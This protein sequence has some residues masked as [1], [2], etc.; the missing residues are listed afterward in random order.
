M[1]VLQVP[2][3]TALRL[4]VLLCGAALLAA[5]ASEGPPATA[6]RQRL[7][8]VVREQPALAGIDGPVGMTAPDT[9]AQVWT[10]APPVT[11][12]T[13]DSMATQA[14]KG[15]AAIDPSGR[16]RAGKLRPDRAPLPQNPAALP[17]SSAGASMARDR[18]DRPLVA[19]T[20]ASPNADVATLAATG[21]LPPDTMGDIGPT[22]YLVT[23]NGRIR[24]IGKTSGSADGVLDQDTDVFFPPAVRGAG[25]T[26]DPRVRYDRRSG[27]WIV[28]MITVAVPNRFVLAVSDGATITPGTTWSYYHWA[29]TRTQAGSGAIGCLADYP[30]LGVDEDALYVGVNQFC[31]TDFSGL[32]FDSVSVY[33]VNKADLVGGTL[34]LAQFDG[35]LASSSSAGIYSPQGVDNVDAN[36]ST[37]YV[38][39]V[40]NRLLGNLILHRIANPGAAPSISGPIDIA[41]PPTSVPVDVPHPGGTLP[42]DGL[43]DRLLQAVVRNGRLWTTHQVEVDAAGQADT[44]GGRNGVRWYELGT[45]GATPAVVQSG[46]V[47]DSAGASPVSYWMGA[48]MANG[49]GHVALGM[50]MAGAAT[51]VNTAFTGRLASDPSAYPSGVMDPPTAYSS[52][53]SFSYNQQVP[54]AT[55]QR[56]GDYSYTSVDPDD[57]MTFWTLQQ[58]VDA[59]NSYAVRLVRLLAPPPAAITSVSP[60]VID[61]GVATVIVTV[62]GSATGGRGFFDPG[63]GF[64]RRIAAAVSGSGVTVTSVTV[65]SPTSL[66]LTL[67]TSVATPGART[68]TIANPDGQTT[69]LAAALT[70]GAS[71]P[72][73]PAFSGAPGDRTLFDAGSGATTGALPF[74]VADPQGSPVTLTASSSN[75]AVIPQNRVQLV[76]P[77][78][79]GHAS[80]A[81]TSVGQHGSSTITLTASDGV[82]GAPGTLSSTWSFVVTV[83]PSAVPGAP[84]DFRVIVVRNRVTFTW[85]PPA[86]TSSEPV[87]GYRLEAGTAPGQTIAAL[88][89][90]NT[91][92]YT[93]FSAPDG[94]FFARLRAQTA[95]G[96]SVPSTEVQFATGQA[97]P[98]LA[99]LALLATVQDTG[100]S[101]QWTENPQGPVIT[102]Y[103]VRA[104]TAPGLTD[105]GLAPLPPTARTFTAIAPPGTYYVRIVA[106]NAAGA[107]AA[108]NEAAIVAQPGTCTIPAA[109]T[110]VVATAAPG[111]LTLRWNAPVSGA[112]PTVY[113][114]HAGSSA[115]A[116][117][118]F[119]VGLPAGLTSASGFVPG[120]PYFIRM[121]AANP[122]GTS[123]PSA[124][125]SA[126]LP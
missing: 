37:G 63:P 4:P 124:E 38:I 74:V 101:L 5:C 35:V 122:C 14:D 43:D 2:L 91:L 10:G 110:G 9:P 72:A 121:F 25:V 48:I 44:S 65:T 81:V 45:L 119:I 113:V 87:I 76:P 20:P 15:P 109:P 83:S 28:L 58:Y 82:P 73:P 69:A 84:E 29:N 6:M 118:R 108:S 86:S 70:I 12:V 89:A 30:S 95:A 96:T 57:D 39:G 33:V 22:Q 100:V 125:T 51:R 13:A 80:V 3:S 94:V 105:L 103:Q 40:D 104:G 117:D 34:S 41:V 21:A 106:M 97:A 52:N 71:T 8:P 102:G 112:I 53:T 116:V 42:L 126:T 79:T 19:Q 88:P 111:R 50:S 55:A 54:P 68:L 93:V 75:P 120:G 23:L 107:G 62:T 115:G 85:Q 17:A 90:G 98:P 24:T 18:G 26:T 31:G 1:V 56:W 7:A 27:R 16:P 60:N 32:G 114:V 64:V 59:P 46:T 78:A 66:T 47:F 11:V 49:Q 36:T 77:D 61:A 67:D 99:P 123:G 92:S